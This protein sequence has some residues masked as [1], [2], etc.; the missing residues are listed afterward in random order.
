[1]TRDEGL[2]R[3]ITTDPPATARH[4]RAGY[5]DYSNHLKGDAKSAGFNSPQL[6]AG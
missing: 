4:K 2:I 1:M 5:T 6:A 3:L